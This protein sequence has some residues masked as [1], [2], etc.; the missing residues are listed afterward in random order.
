[1]THDREFFR[2]NPKD[3]LLPALLYVEQQIN[4]NLPPQAAP[5]LFWTSQR[6]TLNL[7]FQPPKLIHLLWLQF[8]LTVTG[9]IGFRE[10]RVCGVW[11]RIG[12]NSA[13]AN[14]EFCSDACK[15]K[16]LRQRQSLAKDMNAEG[17]TPKE[18]A[19]AVRSKVGTVRKWLDTQKK[20]EK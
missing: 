9:K 2:L 5:E 13:N 19:K 20:E 17:K 7:R 1:L 10:C 15:M 18:I 16:D 11:D 14:R 3:R 4:A 8:A 12:T 6:I